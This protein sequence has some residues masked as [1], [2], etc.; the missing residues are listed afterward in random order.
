M[1]EAPF[2]SSKPLPFCPGCSHHLVVRNTAKAFIRLGMKPLE[3]VLVTDIGCH[4]IVDPY[5]K[6]HTVHGLHGRSAAFGAGVASV[7]N[8]GKVVVYMGDGGASLGIQHLIECARMNFPLTVLVLNNMLYGMTGGQPSSL[9]PCGFH[10]PLRPEGKPDAHYDLCQIVRSAGAPYVSR[11]N[12]A[13]DFTATLVE[14]FE[15]PG[16]SLVE[17][18][19][20]C[21]SYGLKYNPGQKADEIAQ[22]AGL[23][24]GVWRNPAKPVFKL[25]LEFQRESLLKECPIAIQ[26]SAAVQGRRSVLIAGSAGGRVQQ[27]GELLARAAIASGLYTTKKGTYPVTVG[28]GYSIAEVVVGNEPIY[29]T[30]IRQPDVMVVV[31]YDGLL[32]VDRLLGEMKQGLLLID[33]SLSPPPTSAKVVKQPFSKAG[34]KKNAALLATLYLARSTGIIPLEVLFNEVKNAAWGGGEAVSR[35]EEQ[36][37][38]LTG[39]FEK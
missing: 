35:L 4:G 26:G 32:Y 36:L 7:L 2:L 24:F 39:G 19:E 14:A 3:V 15:T 29:F 34:G 27:A 38:Q 22:R 28:T 17:V 10:T 8:Q 18:V 20:T 31:S 6:T 37:K 1:I 9:T 13:G 23:E 21:P 12:G 30:G 11:V 5:F 25:K 33:E 16:F